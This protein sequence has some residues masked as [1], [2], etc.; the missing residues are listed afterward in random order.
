[1]ENLLKL[2]RKYTQEYNDFFTNLDFQEFNIIL[3][4]LQET[5]NSGHSIWIGGNGGSSSISQ[6]FVTDFAKGNVADHRTEKRKIHSLNSHDALVSAISNDI[7]YES[8][9]T[10]QIQ[11]YMEEND[12]LILISSSGNSANVVNAAKLA[13]NSGIK[14]I[15]LTGFGGGE[16]AILCDHKIVVQSRN[17]GVVEDIHMSLLHIAS[18]YLLSK[19]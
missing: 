16:L 9:F 2:T 7:G 8:I 14:S 10:F 5:M 3:K 6:H 4:V 12:L 18:Q 1:M 11:K 15:A 17:Y 19:F 13:S